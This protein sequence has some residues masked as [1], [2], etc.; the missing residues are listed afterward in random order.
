MKSIF[1]RFPLCRL[2]FILATNVTPQR[3]E[4]TC[5][6]CLDPKLNFNVSADLVVKGLF[7]LELT[8]MICEVSNLINLFH[9]GHPWTLVKKKARRPF[10]KSQRACPGELSLAN[11]DS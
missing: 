4:N 11:M 10:A 1:A 9:F 5:D 8:R 3:Q 6:G 2:F 7:A